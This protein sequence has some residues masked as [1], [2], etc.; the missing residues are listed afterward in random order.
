MRPAG[1]ECVSEGVD[2][3]VDTGLCV[4]TCLWIWVDMCGYGWLN[5]L[6]VDRC[7]YVWACVD[8]AWIVWKGVDRCG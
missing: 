1:L 8:V 7:G 4:R 5:G 3:C 6:G 2:M